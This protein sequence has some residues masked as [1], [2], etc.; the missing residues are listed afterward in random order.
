MSNQS[1]QALSGVRVLDLTQFESGTSVT[2]SM[3]WM[4]AE[5]IKLENPKGG[6]QG[7]YAS[8]DKA[9]LDSYYFLVLNA[10]KKSVTLNIKSM[11]GFEMLKDLIRKCDVI[12]ENFTPGYM[13]KLGLGWD[14]V[15]AINPGIIYGRIKGFGAGSPYESYKAFDMIAQATGGIM[16]ITGDR[17]G[18]PIKPGVTMGDTGAGLHLLAGII[19]ALYQRDRTGKGQLV[20]VAM[21]DAM[22]NFCRVAFAAQYRD[23]VAARRAGNQM[24]LGTTAPSDA[25]KCKGGGLNDYCYVY[26]NRANNVQ[27]QALLQVIGKPELAD[28]PR[29]ASPQARADHHVEVNAIVS[30]WIK[31]YDKHE[32]MQLLAQAGVPAGAVLD[33]MELS[34]D[35]SM[36]DRGVFVTVEHDQRGKFTMPGWPVSMS[37]SPNVSSAPPILGAHTDETL[38]SLLN[39]DDAQL[40]SMREEG[41]I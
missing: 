22:I 12:V 36:H 5:I 30:K 2:Q 29:F 24:L 39:L 21:Q 15:H 41:V 3:G 38:R 34:A 33:T 7:R 23:G 4:G 10:N 11:K 20:T 40:A 27:W 37:S 31:D 32:A 6:E 19:A 26:S 13:E 8:A 17:D 1:D 16:S 35:Q 14:E 25:Y 9:G 18:R 28:D